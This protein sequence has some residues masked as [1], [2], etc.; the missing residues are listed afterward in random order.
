MIASMPYM[1]LKINYRNDN[2]DKQ[3]S[4]LLMLTGKRLQFMEGSTTR[5]WELLLYYG[6]NLSQKLVPVLQ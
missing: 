4:A 2:G 3:L 1:V 6:M 5:N